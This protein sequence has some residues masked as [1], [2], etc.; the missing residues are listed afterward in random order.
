[1]TFCFTFQAVKA[2]GKIKLFHLHKSKVNDEKA[3]VLVSHLL[4]HPSLT[5]LGMSPILPQTNLLYSNTRFFYKNSVFLLRVKSS[6]DL[7]KY[8]DEIF[9][10]Y[11]YFS[12]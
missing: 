9:L 2:C 10:M 4:D 11:S 5:T 6:Y 3:R 1:M 12:E 7:A 8:K